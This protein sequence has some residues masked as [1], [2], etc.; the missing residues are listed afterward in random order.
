MVATAFLGVSF[1]VGLFLL[2]LGV[3]S[4]ILGAVIVA[5]ALVPLAYLTV[6]RFVFRHVAPPPGDPHD[7]AVPSTSEAAYDPRIK[8][9]DRV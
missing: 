9:D 5:L 3:V 4:P 2:A 1:L 7:P 8:P 6:A